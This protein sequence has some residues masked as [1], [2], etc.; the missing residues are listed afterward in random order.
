MDCASKSRVAQKATF[1]GASPQGKQARTGAEL[2]RRAGGSFLC[3]SAQDFSTLPQGETGNAD[4]LGLCLMRIAADGLAPLRHRE[5][6][7]LIHVD[8]IRLSPAPREPGEGLDARQRRDYGPALG[9]R[10]RTVS[11]WFPS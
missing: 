11:A 9:R 1:Q 3:A 10:G 6:S 2:L 4:P 7:R 5:R 8:I